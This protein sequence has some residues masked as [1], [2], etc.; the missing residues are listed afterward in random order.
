MNHPSLHTLGYYYG[1]NQANSNTVADPDQYEEA[2]NALIQYFPAIYETLAGKSPREQA[3]ILRSRID[4]LEKLK[5]ITPFLSFVYDDQINRSKYLLQ[6]IEGEVYAQ[7]ETE[8]YFSVYKAIGAGVGI[9]VIGL[10]GS[11]IYFLVKRA[12]S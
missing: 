8:F 3:A 12:Q 1:Q 11:G 10:I 9:A 7:E 5:A 2:K 6:A 4:R